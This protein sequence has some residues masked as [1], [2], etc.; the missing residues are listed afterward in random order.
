MPDI[1]TLH[2]QVV[3]FVIALGLLGV[4]FRI[5]SLLWQK[6]WLNPAAATLLLLAAVAA[7]LGQKSGLDAHGVAERIPGARQAVQEH[8]EWGKR[9]RNAMLVVAGLEILGLIF[10]SKR[11]GRPIRF[12]S[13]ATGLAAAFC[14]YEAAEHGGELVYSYAGGVGTRSGNRE[15]VTRLLVAGLYHEA[16]I[17]RDSGRAEDAARLTDEMLR[18][19]PNDPTVQFLAIESKIRDRKDP[20]GALND[21]AVMQVPA[22]DARLAPRHGMLTAQALVAAGMADSARKVLTDLALRFPQSQAVKNALAN[23]N[24]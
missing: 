5:V 6:S 4:G 16:R 10:A 1:A 8:E 23:L 2:P 7:V 13:A 22:T 9:S 17:G 18:Q 14:I 12:L 19:R 3:H 24:K 20:Q 11:A 15:D 21:L